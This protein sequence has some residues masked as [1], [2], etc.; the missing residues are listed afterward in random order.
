MSSRRYYLKM[1]DDSVINVKETS[2]AQAICT[3]LEACIGRTVKEC[4][5]GDSARRPEFGYTEYEVPAHQ[6]LTEVPAK[7]RRSI[8]DNTV[9]MFADIPTKKG[10]S[11]HRDA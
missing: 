2:A 9:P 7:R 10:A 11:A 3:A 8:P 6:A 1:S 4:W 5:A